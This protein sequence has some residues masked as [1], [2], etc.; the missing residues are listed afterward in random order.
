VAP[1][2]VSESQSR[3]A[4]AQGV[5]I[6]FRDFPFDASFRFVVAS[7]VAAAGVPPVFCYLRWGSTYP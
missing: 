7:S 6:R 1:D 5:S 2:A 3:A 4:E